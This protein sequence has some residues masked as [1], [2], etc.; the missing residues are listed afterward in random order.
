MSRNYLTRTVAAGAV[1][2][3]A[4]TTMAQT[5]ASVQ[6]VY[7]P[8]GALG[9][10][11]YVSQGATGDNAILC[12]TVVGGAVA[13]PEDISVVYFT[14]DGTLIGAPFNVVEADGPA[15]GNIRERNGNGDGT[16][17]T[18]ETW[19]INLAGAG[20]MVSPAPRN[21]LASIIGL[22]LDP[23]GIALQTPANLDGTSLGNA[24]DY[25]DSTDQ[26]WQIMLIRT[27]PVAAY[28]E[29]NGASSDLFFQVQCPLVGLG[30]DPAV[31]QARIPMFG[32]AANFGNPNGL[33]SGTTATA[34]TDWQFTS[35]PQL[36]NSGT[37][38]AGTADINAG[39]YDNAGGN[40]DIVHWQFD[41][42]NSG[43][44]G[45]NPFQVTAAGTT[46]IRDSAGSFLNPTAVSPT[47][48]Q[49]LA[50][51][52]VV[53][54][55]AMLNGGGT[56]ADACIV[57]WN[58][59][60]A[61]AGNT[62]FYDIRFDSAGVISDPSGLDT[63]STVVDAN[64]TTQ[65]NLAVTQ[66]NSSANNILRDGLP[67]GSGGD[68]NVVKAVMVLDA[69]GVAPIP[70]FGTA[71]GT[72]AG[73]FDI[74]DMIPPLLQFCALGDRTLDGYPEAIFLNF[75][76]P[77]D[78]FSSATGFELTSI[79]GVTV[80]P[81]S[82]VN[83]LNGD[84]GPGAATANST[85]LDENVIPIAAGSFSIP[86][87]GSGVNV[88]DLDVNRNGVIEPIE[89]NST[90]QL[91]FDN[92]G[93]QWDHS[94]PVG[95]PLQPFPDTGATSA[96]GG[97]AD[98]INF[99]MNFTGSDQVNGLS[100]NNI[101]SG[102]AAGIVDANGNEM[103]VQ[104]AP[105]SKGVD[106]DYAAPA[107]VE[108]CFLSGDNMPNYGA[109]NTQSIFEQDGTVG[110]NTD[111]I[112][113]IIAGENFF[114]L[115]SGN[116]DESLI[117]IGIEGTAFDNDPDFLH[118]VPA[119]SAS[120]RANDTD[121]KAALFPGT[122]SSV[123]FDPSGAG[124]GLKDALNNQL[125]Y[126]T[127]PVPDCTAPYIPLVLDVNQI[128]Q[129]GAFLIPDLSG[130]FVG[131]ILARF[132][133]PINDT[134]VDPDDFAVNFGGD[135]TGA[136]VDPTDENIVLF[137]VSGSIG[138]NNTVL[139]TYNG[140][141]SGATLVASQ[142]PPAGNG[143]A[144]SA[145]TDFA[146][147][148][149]LQQPYRNSRDISIMDITGTGI[150]ADGS[151]WPLGTKLYAFSAIPVVKSIT[152]THNNIPFTYK[153]DDTI[154]GPN[155]L[156]YN[157]DCGGFTDWVDYPN[158]ASLSAFNNW[159]QGLP[160]GQ[161]VYLSRDECNNQYFTNSKTNQVIY[162]DDDYDDPSQA[163]VLKDVISVNVRTG[164]G[165]GLSS[166]TF[167]GNGE[168]NSNT[169]K[170]G[171]TTMGWDVIRTNWWWTNSAGLID[172]YQW[173][174]SFAGS[175]V[176]MGTA[177]IDNPAGNFSM[178]VSQPTSAFNGIDRLNGVDR[179]V[180]F[181]L[182]FPDGRRCALS[183]LLLSATS[184]DHDGDGVI[185]DAILF[186]S[187]QLTQ[188]SGTVATTVLNFDLRRVGKQ[189]VYP[190]WNVVP[191]N[192]NLGVATSNKAL[193]TLPAGVTSN[194]IVTYNTSTLP[195]ATPINGAIFWAEGSSTS[196]RD[197][198]WTAADDDV[199]SF[200]SSMYLDANLISNFA[201]TMTTQGIKM[202]AGIDAL[203]PGYAMGFFNNASVPNDPTDFGVTMFGEE[204]SQN[205]VFASNPITSNNRN[206]TQGW[207]L[208]AVTM[209]HADPTAFFSANPGSNYVIV[210]R[211]MGRGPDLGDS[212]PDTGDVLIDVRSAD[213][214]GPNDLTEVGHE[215][216]FIH[217][218]N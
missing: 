16:I 177:V 142:D 34:S 81:F 51:Q 154:Y 197:G 165:R 155:G 212:P 204:L 169:L 48:L 179:P 96:T 123:I 162:A 187:N 171:S 112:L 74:T 64:D 210:F 139:F 102:S 83:P 207:I 215:G 133:Q 120:F 41:Q 93:Y 116:I 33:L 196:D 58:R 189:V 84:L 125:A 95:D 104:G 94:L 118:Q 168:N 70:A 79:D 60:L 105:I 108:S 6:P 205:A 152:A 5:L 129:P 75:G 134:T 111:N 191:M 53:W 183:S 121:E 89:M 163:A 203:V 23:T 216:A 206:S 10:M 160:M 175:P 46:N 15:A 117:Q 192:R 45:P 32:D 182:E 145:Y 1:A 66:P 114:N 202:G 7:N 138:I 146:S 130:D 151:P 101:V 153:V 184:N 136:A 40:L 88:I 188:T 127:A 56:I 122:T 63:N 185:G 199:S 42:G 73:T 65:V 181:V 18:G 25:D 38:P 170:S 30:P 54:K 137:D 180:I 98:V 44:T 190:E 213:T 149:K 194:S 20:A 107:L 55:E 62:N 50:V 19:S 47:A 135:V 176:I 147:I 156:G 148:K 78:P 157:S 132:T 13:A 143:A 87:T 86:D 37:A 186:N 166:L 31:D 85:T 178:H 49:A 21:P 140:G 109:N 214:T 69:G 61:T 11:E 80:Y 131:S 208:G 3:F 39:T 26:R 218:F 71:G 159:L 91:T 28:R 90:I 67:A 12:F 193:P 92:L 126:N 150:G 59:P 43:L 77:I 200:F 24:G 100:G 22:N 167:T 173:G 195:N 17:D 27:T 211:N 103:D 99:F 35:G 119:N 172:Y 141:V 198:E 72:P 158:F 161:S 217:Y 174:Y 164:G 36:F 113:F 209:D 97:R 128:A 82:W 4:G 124:T 2:A 68:P 115:N 76:E 29:L 9:N 52:M 110:D 106:T 201:F 144:V 14:A 8:P 57:N